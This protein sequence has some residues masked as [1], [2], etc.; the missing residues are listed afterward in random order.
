M[1]FANGLNVRHAW[2]HV[3]VISHRNGQKGAKVDLSKAQ[4]DTG[5]PKGKTRLWILHKLR[6]ELVTDHDP[7]G[8]PTVYQ[9]IAS[10]MGEDHFK[11]M[12]VVTKMKNV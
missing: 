8:R 9:R 5:A 12:V 1:D 3:H 10:M 7:D 6:Q 11:K 2:F 4:L